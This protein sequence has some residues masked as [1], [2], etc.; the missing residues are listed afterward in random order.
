M[1]SRLL[2]GGTDTFVFL[3]DAFLMDLDNEA[4]DDDVE[5]SDTFSRAFSKLIVYYYKRYSLT[6]WNHWGQAR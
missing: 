6:T 4:E 5:E 3:G 1:S 2:I